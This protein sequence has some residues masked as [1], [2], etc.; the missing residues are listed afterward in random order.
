MY[1]YKPE[2][3]EFAVVFAYIYE[4]VPNWGK[5]NAVVTIKQEGESDIEVDVT[6]KNTKDRFCVIASFKDNGNGLTV[7]KEEKYFL[8]HR[9]VDKNY[10]FGFSWVAGRK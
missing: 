1:F 2:M 5:T 6:S 3:I 7:T 4:G 8:G 10:G 9:E